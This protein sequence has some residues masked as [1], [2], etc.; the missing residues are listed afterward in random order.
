[1]AFLGQNL[2][3]CPRAL[4]MVLGRIFWLGYFIGACSSMPCN[5]IAYLYSLVVTRLT[6]SLDR[7]MRG[8]VFPSFFDFGSKFCV[9]NL[10]YCN[11]FFTY[12]IK[13]DL[14]HSLITKSVKVITKNMHK[15]LCVAQ[16]V[17]PLIRGRQYNTERRNKC[18][19]VPPYRASWRRLLIDK[20]F[21]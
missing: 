5:S 21:F 3:H 16:N 4:V 18:Y 8:V 14:P 6:V 9:T 15:T 20:N 2:G 10:Q 1:M 19:D 17:V 12:L 11:F 7:E 13:L